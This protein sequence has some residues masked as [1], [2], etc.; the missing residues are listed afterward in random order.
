LH[1]V[2]RSPG[3]AT[4]PLVHMVITSLPLFSGLVVAGVPVTDA[5]S[6]LHYFKEEGCWRGLSEVDA[7]GHLHRAQ[8]KWMD[9]CTDE[10]S[11]YQ[12][13]LQYLAQPVFATTMRP[14]CRWHVAHPGANLLTEY[15]TLE[16]GINPASNED[17][18][19]SW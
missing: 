6:L 10:L 7:Q 17:K 2:R 4:K 19:D 8:S 16:Y 3:L 12:Y 15:V 5:A 13:L 18:A 14:F 11:F 1:L 9:Y